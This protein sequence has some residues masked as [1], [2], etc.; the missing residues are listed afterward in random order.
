VAF[1]SGAP[2]LV[3]GDGNSLDD[4]FAHDRS[5]VTTTAI[6]VDLA[7][8]QPIGGASSSPALS[9]DGRFAVFE[10]DATNLVMGDTNGFT[11]IFMRDR[12]DAAGP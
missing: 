12:G 9:A 4:V 2:D 7:G 3:A 10:S 11:D 6:S 1:R 5:T 8:N